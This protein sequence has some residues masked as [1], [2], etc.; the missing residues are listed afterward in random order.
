MLG[1]KAKPQI[2]R[3]AR[4][5]IVMHFNQLGRTIPVFLDASGIVDL[6]KKEGP[7][8]SSMSIFYNFFKSVI[9]YENRETK[10][11]P[12]SIL[13]LSGKL[14]Y[15]LAPTH[16][17]VYMGSFPVRLLRPSLGSSDRT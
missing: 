17:R 8:F 10:A 16:A 11:Y 9:A 13:S 2:A 14:L 6:I 3:E 15:V 1:D 7:A 5:N 12:S 4:R